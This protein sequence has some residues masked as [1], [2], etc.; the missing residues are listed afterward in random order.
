M[1]KNKWFLHGGR[2]SGRILRLLYVTYENKIADLE[3][4]NA[5]LKAEVDKIKQ[6]FE[7]QVFTDLMNEV[8]TEY[9]LQEKN[10]KLVIENA[11]LK[12]K[13]NNLVESSKT[14]IS[15]SDEIEART[16][17]QL[18]EAKAIIKNLMKFAEIDSREYEKEYKEAEKFLKECEKE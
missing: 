4:E 3:K 13:N 5:R 18:T 8:E 1:N 7:P 14:I 12:E 2:G 15:L 9:K 6:R 16:M 10:K 11:E 17:K